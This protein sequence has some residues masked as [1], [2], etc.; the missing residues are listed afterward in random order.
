MRTRLV[1]AV[2]PLAVLGFAVA[3][4]SAAPKPMKGEFDAAGLPDPTPTATEVC[5]GLSPVSRTEV[6]L[7]IP[8]AGKL[9]VELTGF[10][11]DWDL[12]VENKDGEIVGESAGFVEA[13]T[14]TIQIKLKKAA[15][16]TIVACNFAGGPVASGSYEYVPNK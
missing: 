12:T 1:L 10:E 14:E 11:G 5:Q 16:L 6:P 9:K 2:L 3:P 4:S 8:A 7:K 13:T 15:E